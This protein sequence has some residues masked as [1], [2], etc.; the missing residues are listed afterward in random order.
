MRDNPLTPEIIVETLKRSNLK[1]VLVEGK[2][3]IEIYKKIENKLGVRN[4]DFLP[5]GGRN[6]LLKVYERKDEINNILLMFIADSDSWI[7]SNIPLEYKEIFFTKGYCLENDLFEDG[8]E[9]ILNILDL[10][11]KRRFEQI[12]ENV[13]EWF[14]FEIEQ[15]DES[16][17]TD[18]PFCDISLLSTSIIKKNQNTLCNGFLISRNYSIPN[19]EFLTEIRNNYSL[20]LRGKFI[21]QIFEKIFQERSVAKAIKYHRRQ[22]LD[23]CFIEGTKDTEKES[24]MN[25]M[26]AEIRNFTGQ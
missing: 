10:D 24:N 7:F 20:K 13:C 15:I 12:I 3:D 4:V 21:Y 16:S 2:D 11:E 18:S 9:L 17:N 14:A 19:A 5:C 22:L 25:K 8:K 1:T 26:I 23:L 6:T